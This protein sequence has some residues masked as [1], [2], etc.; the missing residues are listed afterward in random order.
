M[1]FLIFIILFFTF[2]CK[3]E[4]PKIWLS[5]HSNIFKFEDLL[6]LKNSPI[7][8]FESIMI[9]NGL[10]DV[11][12]VDS[13]LVID[14]KYASS[15]NFMKKDLYYCLNKAYLQ[16][17]VADMLKKSSFYLQLIEPSY[18]IIVFDAARPLQVQQL[19]WDSFDKPFNEKIKFLSNPQNGSI[20]NFGAAVD[21][22]IID[23]NG[24]LLDM[25]TEFDCDSK[26]SYPILEVQFFSKGKLSKSQL[27]NRILLRKVMS[28]GG[29]TGIQTEWWHFNAMSRENA[30]NKFEII[31]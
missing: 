17:E 18:R 13:S 23:I 26:L 19:M 24:N 7:C 3:S 9:K 30:K 5:S 20:H 15:D 10:V 29:F 27:D 1:K 12:N 2:S 14:I 4:K 11:A 21:V 16:V 22:S 28:F 25:G 8:Y 6:T 31:K